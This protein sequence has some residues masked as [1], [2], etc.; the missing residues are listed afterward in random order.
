VTLLGPKAQAELRQ[1]YAHAGIYAA[2]SRYEPFGLAP[3][4]A[5]LSRCALAMSDNPVFHELW[6]DAAVFFKQ[7]DAED[8][9]RQIN[10]LR[11]ETDLRERGRDRAFQTASEKFTAARMVAEYENAYQQLLSR[12]RVA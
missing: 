6:G 7:D 11:H 8:C 1:I 3:V 10:R 4:E 12:V 5:A 9:A 2:P